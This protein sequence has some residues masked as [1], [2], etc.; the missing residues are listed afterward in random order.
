MRHGW[1]VV[2][3]VGVSLNQSLALTA[4]PA[5]STGSPMV[6]SSTEQS[7]TAQASAAQPRVGSMTVA[8][9][10]LLSQGPSWL[11]TNCIPSGGGCSPRTVPADPGLA[12]GSTDLV[13]VSNV[14]M[15]E[16]SKSGSYLAQQLWLE[17]TRFRRH[18]GP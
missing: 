13:E 2:L 10:P 14:A 15:S 6:S 8:E 16:W 1:V 11:A 18:R 5:P 7:R 12:V 9:G 17:L 3:F 4:W